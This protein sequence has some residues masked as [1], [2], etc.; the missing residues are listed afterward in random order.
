MIS[1]G[2]YIHTYTFVIQDAG[3]AAFI[4]ADDSDDDGPPSLMAASSS[5][6]E[7]WSEPGTPSPGTQSGPV[8]TSD[9][10]SIIT[11][12]ISSVDSIV[13]EEPQTQDPPDIHKV[14]DVLA[15]G[16]AIAFI[17]Y[18]ISMWIVFI[19]QINVSDIIS[20]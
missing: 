2:Y 4:I 11:Q 18:V 14:I 16:T 17:A 20:T 10:D 13:S 7:T 15:S 5:S 9:L 19:T 6:S 1:S 8:D 12:K 3:E